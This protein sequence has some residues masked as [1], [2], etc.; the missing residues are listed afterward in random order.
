[1]ALGCMGATRVATFV[2]GATLIAG[3]G[4]AAGT[5]SPG[6]PS[7]VPTTAPNVTDLPSRTTS[8]TPVATPSLADDS[9][10]G[11]FTYSREGVILLLEMDFPAIECDD[12]RIWD[13]LEPAEDGTPWEYLGCSV[14]PRAF[15]QFITDP[16][17]R[18]RSA[19]AISIDADERDSPLL[20]AVVVA[21]TGGAGESVFLS[22]QAA[23]EANEELI[24][25]EG[26][27]RYKASAP[28]SSWMVDVT[29]LR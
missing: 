21:A 26:G 6:P 8:P 1:M 12:E 17:G 5:T 4:G 29:P 10:Y 13:S 16:E 7:S 2:F 20:R 23:L 28:L 3:C 9:P 19:G 14:G 18:L 25:A 11:V 24:I 15:V 27:Y 22:L